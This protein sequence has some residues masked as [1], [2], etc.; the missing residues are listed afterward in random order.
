MSHI[1]CPAAAAAATDVLLRT[2]GHS[3]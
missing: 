3:E 1:D 2:S